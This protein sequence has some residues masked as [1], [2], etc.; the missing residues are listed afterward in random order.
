MAPSSTKGAVTRL[1]RNAAI[2]VTVFQFPC[3]T[4]WTSRS[5]CGARPYRRVIVVDT[6]VSSM[7]TSLLGSSLFCRRCNALRAAATSGRSCS[8]A[9]KLFF[10]GQLQMMQKPRDRRLSDRDL[11]LLQSVLEFGQRDVRLLRYQLPHQILVRR[12][13]E[14]FV[15]AEFGRV[16]AAR[17]PVKLEEAD[18]RTD[19][20]PALL[21]SFRDGGP[22]L[23]RPDHSPT[24]IRRIWLRHACRPPPSRQLESYSRRYGNPRFSLSGKRSNRGFIQRA[25]ESAATAI[26][27]DD[28]VAVEPVI[29]RDTDGVAGSPDIAST[30]F[31]KIAAADVV[32]VDVSIINSA[33][34]GR[35]SP[36]PNVLIEL[37]YALRALGYERV[38]LVFNRAY[39]AIEDLPFDLRT[40]RI[41]AY[42]VAEDA[43]GKSGIRSDLS[44]R[45]DIAIRA[46]LAQVPQVEEEP[47]VLAAVVA[48]E[49]GQGNRMLV[50]RRNLTAILQQLD[51]LNPTKASAGGTVEE[52]EKA[53]NESR[54][55]VL[56][57]S[58]FAEAI[59]AMNDA[60]AA[61]EVY[62]WF[63]NIF[64]RYH[65]PEEFS[66]RYSEADFDFF[67]FV[68]HELVV[69][70][71]ACLLR[72]K[73]LELIAELLHEPVPIRYQRR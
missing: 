62:R 35:P 9:R 11:F 15:A 43:A 30:I 34:G 70:L 38:I 56:E 4:F 60:E 22:A 49:A 3:S 52:L 8:A 23:D 25:L 18:D 12:Q 42:E 73:R 72:E 58:K 48:I 24:Q 46:A 45:L 61:L 17:L 53:L 63:G 32:V 33:T 47:A 41:L 27:G 66:G 37:G 39:G 69:T 67:R 31:A 57:F 1:L 64:E 40:R 28:T 10:K 13:R 29:D 68:G 16:D 36:N 50:L 5:P 65:L 51:R 54:E 21:R 55:P 20:D 14:I 71:F 7:N 19:A 44:K 26:A 6:L 59:A 2:N